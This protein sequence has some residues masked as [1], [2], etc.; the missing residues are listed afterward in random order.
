MRTAS[1][2][3]V[4]SLVWAV[5]CG[6]P[7]SPVTP[8]GA[9][10]PIELAQLRDEVLSDIVY[11]FELSLP[12]SMDE[13]IDGRV[14][15][16]FAWND[17]SG[18][19]LVLDFKAPAE[20]VRTV[21]V[22]GAADGYRTVN[23][24]V[25]VPAAAL[26]PG[27]NSMALEFRAGD[28]A[29]NRNET[30]LY[31]LFVPDRARFSLPIF[32]QP[33]LKARY[34][35]TL[36]VPEA[37]TAVANAPLE[38]EE[39]T[40]E[41][42]TRILRFAETEPLPTYLFAF[43]AG[44]FE[45]DEAERD[46]RTLR[47]IH[48]ET[49]EEKLARNRDAIFDLHFDALEW[50]EEYT[51][52]PYPFPKLDFVLVPFFQYGGMEHAGAIFYRAS[53]L[54]LDESATQDQYLSRAS[55]IAHESAHM[56]FGDL[57]TMQWFDD[58]WLKEVFANFMAAK[59]VNPAFPEVNH[60][61]RFLLYHHPGAYA[62][63]RT[64]GANPI[65][66][67]LENLDQAGTLYGAIIYQK[68]PVMMKQL[69]LLVGDEVFRQGMRDY[70]NRFEFA[71]ATWYD[72]IAILDRLSPD[73]LEAW[74][75]VWVDQPGRPELITRT[76]LEADRI[77]RL[78][79]L[80][81][82]PAGEARVW[83]QAVT[84][85][86]GYR[87]SVEPHPVRMTGPSASLDSAVGRPRPDFVLPDA[88]GKGY[89]NF[90]LDERSRDYLL[91]H[92]PAI[93]DPL[94]R[95]AAW[96]TL[97]DAVQEGEVGP[98]DFLRLCLRSLDT[99]ADELNV[100]R[101]LRYLGRTFWRLQTAEQRTAVVGQVEELL[102]RGLARAEATS[103]K[104]AF[105]RA[106]RDMALTPDGIERLRAIWSEEVDIPGLVLS[107]RDLTDLAFELAVREVEGW[108]GIL[109]RQAERIDNP[110]RRARFDFIRPALSSDPEV[111]EE[112]FE[113]FREEVNREHEPWVVSSLIYLHH[114]LR[115]EHAARFITPSLE[116]LEEI[117]RTGDIFFPKSWL[118]ATIWGHSSTG[119]A[120][121]VRTFLEAR[122]D[123]PPR[124][125]GKILQSA[126]PLFRAASIVHGS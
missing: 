126:D 15:I 120:D 31:T 106:Y 113:S 69:E 27:P 65:R 3:L 104:G 1:L 42:T 79:L 56:W 13:P 71:N 105:F 85:L 2:G 68:A 11:D 92:L 5:G 109:D 87:D 84:V 123:Y 77:G 40:G 45:V 16:S 44:E 59:I 29:L 107:E 82:D 43:A 39:V 37:W 67:P 7:E 78:E 53:R 97:W 9:G 64:A 25:V 32:D 21:V 81:E 118:D 52:I 41:A 117:Q 58:V 75:R 49:D 86:L 93:D 63:D 10:V 62:V 83:P 80:Q 72:L 18:R 115:A 91:A 73:R 47:M 6:D 121:Q 102:W 23:D 124:L 22:N 35:L 33:S 30:F 20:R 76:E 119:A 57:V 17:P 66:Q 14:E 48:R 90:R 94:V 116:L 24:H 96:V 125:R 28:E 99:E 4:L 114:P 26:R 12:A 19:D 46:G 8:T 101:I 100:Q 38:S 51:A 74:S 122:P 70:L 89:A 50:L 36:E 54:L 103:L 111:R 88:S 98:S 112:R 60:D 61:L 110:D 55:L 34:R 95:G 108:E